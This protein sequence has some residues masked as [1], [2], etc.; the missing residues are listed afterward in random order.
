MYLM[1]S[2]VAGDIQA[3]TLIDNFDKVMIENFRKQ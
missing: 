3:K 2:P 1:K